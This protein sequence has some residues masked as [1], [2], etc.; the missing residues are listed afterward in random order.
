MLDLLTGPTTPMVD[1]GTNILKGLNTGGITPEEP[2]NNAYV[3]EL[4]ESE[5]VCT[6]TKQL[7]VML[8]ASK[9]T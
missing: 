8:D 1:L 3:E 6:A 2:F 5:H 4:Y 7:R 9:F